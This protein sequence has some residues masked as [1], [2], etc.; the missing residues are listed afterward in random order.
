MKA[1]RK[2]DIGRGCGK[3]CPK[4]DP[5]SYSR[6]FNPDSVKFQLLTSALHENQLFLGGVC[7]LSHEADDVMDLLGTG[8]G[9]RKMGG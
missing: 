6:I 8:E 2:E 9:D 5:R 1:S 3:T 7:E 4:S